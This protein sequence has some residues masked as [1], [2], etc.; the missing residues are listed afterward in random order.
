MN[1]EQLQVNDVFVQHSEEEWATMSNRDRK[2]A[3][4]ARVLAFLGYC[5]ST[6]RVHFRTS[7]GDWCIPS[8]APVST[9]PA[10]ELGRTNHERKAA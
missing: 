6:D 5:T 1:A 10:Y 7:S 3:K 9:R 2:H 8:C 4:R